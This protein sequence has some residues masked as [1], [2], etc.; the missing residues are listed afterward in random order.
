MR[1][2]SA[3]IDFSVFFP[4]H[5]IILRGVNAMMTSVNRDTFA[6]IQ[7]LSNSV[8]QTRR[9]YACYLAI[10]LY[11]KYHMAYG[12][13]IHPSANLSISATNIDPFATGNILLYG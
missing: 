1:T 10:K 3:F 13:G 9:I 6:E 7:Q 2:T 8:Y 11:R 5:C 12:G 4:L